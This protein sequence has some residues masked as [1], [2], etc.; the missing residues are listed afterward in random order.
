MIKVTLASIYYLVEPSDHEHM[1]EHVADKVLDWP[2]DNCIIIG[3][4]SNAKVGI[5]LPVDVDE[6]LHKCLGPFGMPDLNKKGRILLDLIRSNDW[7]VANAYFKH[8]SHATWK[9]FSTRKKKHQIDHIIIDQK[10]C[11]NIL[12]C[13]VTHCGVVSDHC[14]LLLKLGIRCDKRVY[15]DAKKSI[16]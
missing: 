13:K 2:K 6:L 3:Q 12:D 15:R 9:Y 1:V 5:R 14:G 7:I 10:T 8:Q 11:K 4:D 16:K